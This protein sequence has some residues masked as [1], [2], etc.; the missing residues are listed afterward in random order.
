VELL[1]T[2]EGF[3]SMYSVTEL[4]NRLMIRFPIY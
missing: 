4:D 2:Q 3:Y 1:A